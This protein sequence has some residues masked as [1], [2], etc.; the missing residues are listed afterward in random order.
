MFMPFLVMV[1][2]LHL[3]QRAEL[4]A[5]TWLERR[6]LYPIAGI[7][8]IW[9]FGANYY[10]EINNNEIVEGELL[11]RLKNSLLRFWIFS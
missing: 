1:K 10:K 5:E 2:G 11:L 4:T 8:D 7:R 6:K 9:L 3:K